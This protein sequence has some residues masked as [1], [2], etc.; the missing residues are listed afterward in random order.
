MPSTPTN[1]ARCS[2]RRLLAG[3]GAA[4]PIGL[5]GLVG[6][7]P[8]SLPALTPPPR[9]PA[10]A[11]PRPA[12]PA[13]PT[14]PPLNF[15]RATGSSIFD[16]SGKPVTLS[17]LNWFGME[18]TTLAP[19]GLWIRGYRDMLEQMVQAGYNCLRLP[20]SNDLF[21][22]ALKP[23]GI[24]FTR[25]P[26]LK[27]LSGLQI[28]DT[29]VV[30]AGE[31]GMKIFLDQHRPNTGA[32]SALWY[33]DHLSQDDWL[34]QW[35]A[36]AE[37]YLGNDAVVGADLHNEPAGPCTWGS[38][39]PKTDWAIAAELCGNAIL[40]VNPN[41]LILVEGI[42]KLVD[43]SGNVLDWT[44]Q[45]GEL[46]G[47]RT[48]PIHL[49]VPNRLVYSPHDY[50][51]SVSNQHWF[52][53]P[54]FP[55][56]L[57]AFWDQHWAFLKEDGTAPILVGEFG[58]PS[59]GTDTEGLWQRTLVDYIKAKGLH[60]TYWCWNPNSADTGGLLEDDWLTIHPDKQALLKADLGSD[61]KNVAPSVV[62]E[63]AV[64][65]VTGSTGAAP[66]PATS[67]PARRTYVVQSGDTLSGIAG[68]VYGD[69][70]AWPRLAAA[71]ASWLHDPNLLRPGQT[72]TIPS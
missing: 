10:T 62:N 57:P 52:S 5:V 45:G 16:V 35:R 53:D 7:Q 13:R 24:D 70:A 44:W 4:M 49:S 58:G 71:N 11:F 59:V 25:N 56:N 43:K 29:I 9:P 1:D 26:D 19:D 42:E 15:L 2:R 68:R 51:P 37:R 27:G 39:D 64:P 18:T 48:R 65:P 66:T 21:N 28:M 8:A 47:A 63:R 6:C 50:G 20:F 67:Q 31:R 55:D 69:P 33:T 3:C 17:G 12:A 32:Q 30:A 54:A 34:T 22:P 14:P 23:N 46:M 41:W 60:F 40:A 38:G 72:L 61:L 36:L